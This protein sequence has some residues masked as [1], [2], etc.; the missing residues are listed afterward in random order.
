MVQT[1][2]RSK[3]Q[4]IPTPDLE[5]TAAQ[6]LDAMMQTEAKPAD[7]EV[8][9]QVSKDSRKTVHSN[10][11]RGNLIQQTTRIAKQNSKAWELH[12]ACNARGKV[13]STRDGK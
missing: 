6:S 13:T 3:V 8:Q 2:T 9:S 4:N 10:M 7:S 12:A 11:R 1:M 5:Q